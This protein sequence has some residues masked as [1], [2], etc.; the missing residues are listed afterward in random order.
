MNTNTNTNTGVQSPAMPSESTKAQQLVISETLR[1]HWCVQ[2]DDNTVVPLIAIDE[3]PGSVVLKGIPMTLTVLEALKARMELVSG[4]H[5]THGVRYQ[6]D[7][8]ITTQTVANEEG[9]NSGSDD[10]PASEGSECSTQKGSL[11][12]DKK[13]KKNATGKNKS[14]VCAHSPLQYRVCLSLCAS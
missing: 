1:P 14:A 8:P 5:P 12:S 7:Q 13:G 10:S 4:N 9:D 2:R 11:A 6:L 3:L